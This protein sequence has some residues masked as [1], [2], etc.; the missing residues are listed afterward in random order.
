MVYGTALN[1]EALQSRNVLKDAVWKT[2]LSGS[3]TK[4]GEEDLAL[5][6]PDQAI[7][8]EGRSMKR[9]APELYTVLVDDGVE[10]RLK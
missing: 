2:T 9:F 7:A 5:A 4:N 10:S 6:M 1:G 8:D 3:L